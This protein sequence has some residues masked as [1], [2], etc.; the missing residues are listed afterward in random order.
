MPSQPP[1]RYISTRSPQK[2]HTA[3]ERLVDRPVV[4]EIN[5]IEGHTL[6]V[7]TLPAP[8][9][10]ASAVF[11]SSVRRFPVDVVAKTDVLAVARIAGIMA[12]MRT[13]D[14]IPLCH[15]FGLDNVSVELD[16]RDS[17]VEIESTACLVARTGVE[18]E[19]LTAVSVAALTIY[20]MCKAIDK[21]MVIADVHLVEKRK[22]PADGAEL[23]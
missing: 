12:A 7:E 10:V 3:R 11:F 2:R 18:M 19:A 8:Q 6:I 20:D 13:G 14:L 15:P 5:D 16:V 4:A 9:V 22:E 17:S 23:K 1:I 21:G